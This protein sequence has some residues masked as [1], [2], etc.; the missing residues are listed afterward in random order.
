M[1]LDSENWLKASVEYENNSFQHL[2]NVVT[3]RG[4]SDWATTE[5][6]PDI[7]IMWYRLS[8]RNDD[9]CIECSEDGIKFK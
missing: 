2:G 5:I 4:Y 6:S 9:Y 3:N 7:K 8:R 1:Y